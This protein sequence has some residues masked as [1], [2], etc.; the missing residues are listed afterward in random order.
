VLVSYNDFYERQDR[1]QR[2]ENEGPYVLGGSASSLRIGDLADDP[3]PGQ[4]LCAGRVTLDKIPL[5]PLGSCIGRERVDPPLEFDVVIIPESE[6]EAIASLR[7]V[8][9]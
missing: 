4:G 1:E 5:R 8:S 7:T 3:Y 9:A 2:G 6:L